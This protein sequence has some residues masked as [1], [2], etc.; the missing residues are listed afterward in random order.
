MHFRVNLFPCFSRS[1]HHIALV[2]IL[3]SF[4]EED[5]KKKEK[6]KTSKTTTFD[7]THTLCA[8][9]RHTQQILETHSCGLRST[10]E[11]QR[12]ST[13]ETKGNK[14]QKSCQNYNEYK[15]RWNLSNYQQSLEGRSR[16]HPSRLQAS[17]LKYRQ[18]K[19]NACHFLFNHYSKK[20]IPSFGP[21]SWNFFLNSDFQVNGF[22][23]FFSCGDD[24]FVTILHKI[25]SSLKE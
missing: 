22:W 24:K 17:S 21:N 3:S 14:V 8:L 7:I 15:G 25:S 13:S 20:V 4:P 2:S 16:R 5:S 11:R 12:R 19:S 1:P 23:W 6:R 9:T 18:T 10:G